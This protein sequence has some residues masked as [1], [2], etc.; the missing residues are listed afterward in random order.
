MSYSKGYPGAPWRLA[1]RYLAD[2]RI[3]IK[4]LLFEVATIEDAYKAIAQ[5]AEPG[6]VKG[7]III[8][9]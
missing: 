2:G 3:D 4:P 7:K 9:M 5:Y 8:K 6:A 1:A